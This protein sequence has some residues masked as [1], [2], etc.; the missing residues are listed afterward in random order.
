MKST[1]P[2][3]G[4]LVQG[5]FFTDGRKFVFRLAGLPLSGVGD[6]PDAAF[7]DLMRIEAETTPLST[8]MRALARDQEGERVRGRIIRLAAIALIVFGVVGGALAAS[9]ALAP[10]VIADIGAL[11][12]S[13]LVASMQRL[14]PEREAK[15]RQAVQHLDGV[16]GIGQGG[17]CA[18]IPPVGKSSSAP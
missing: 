15:L 4:A 16:I 1:G 7:E 14:T 3:G 2:D 6:T 10:S 8:R 13:K 12:T 18:A 9:A 5:E 11:A 17:G